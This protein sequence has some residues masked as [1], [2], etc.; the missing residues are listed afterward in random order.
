MKEYMMNNFSGIAEFETIYEDADVLIRTLQ[1]DEDENESVLLS[2]TG[3]GH[4]MGPMNVQ[5]PEFVATGIRMGRV[6]FIS[7]LN[8]TWGNALDFALIARIL[9]PYTKD[10]R[11]FAIGNSM[12]GFLSVLANN[13]IPIEVAISFSSQFS[14]SPEIVPEERRYLKYT[15]NITTFHYES[16]DGYFNDRTRYFMFFGDSDIEKRHW[17][18]FTPHPTLTRVVV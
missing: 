9:E 17:G 12:G 1:I 6:I 16:L 15:D 2:F 10:R 4:A 8:R 7:D 14:V 13:H 18:R 5:R 11:V 3:I